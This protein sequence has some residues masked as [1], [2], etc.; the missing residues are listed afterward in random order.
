MTHTGQ[1][2]KVP[3]LE[4]LEQAPKQ[5]WTGIYVRILA[6]ILIYGAV[7]HV[8]NIAGWSGTRWVDTPV[9][10]R[11]MDVVLLAFN[12]VV[13]IALW[14]RLP[15]SLVAFIIGIIALQLIPYTIF[16]SH[17]IETPSQAQ[18]LN[19]LIATHLIL[20]AVLAGLILLRR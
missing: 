20:L 12:I 18:A 14:F 2:R 13:A 5:T 3:I 8:G 16:R 15:W 6:C 10:W 4:I 1:S 7:M 17:F 19:G 11:V 9:L